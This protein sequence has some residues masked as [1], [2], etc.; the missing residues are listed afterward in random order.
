MLGANSDN[1]SGKNKSI[2]KPK[3]EISD[4]LSGEAGDYLDELKPYMPSEIVGGGVPYVP[5]H[6]EEAVW[7]AASQACATEKVHFVYTVEGNKVW[8]LAC[9]SSAFASN[10]D[11][12]CPL[13]AA[14]PGNS[15]YWDKETVYIFDQD[16]TAGALRWDPDTGRMQ[17]FIGASRTLLPKVQSMDTVNFVN[18]DA[19]VAEPVPWKNR[20][21]KTEQLSRATARVLLILGILINIVAIIIL[22]YQYANV[23]AMNRDLSGVEIQ[24]RDAT[25][26]L[27]VNAS[28]FTKSDGIKHIVRMQEI[29]DALHLIEGQLLKYEVDSKGAVTWEAL[30]PNIFGNDTVAGVRIE[31]IGA[32]ARGRARIKGRR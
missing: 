24:T 32:E 15:E 25:Q 12:W 4:Y 9:P 27:L 18:I 1:M 2:K 26:K 31:R 3:P 19:E 11:S 10:P 5:G 17:V 28:E 14:L 20:A 6:E 23:Y 21:L 29:N 16:G 22:F 13:A 7:N 8:Y 30:V